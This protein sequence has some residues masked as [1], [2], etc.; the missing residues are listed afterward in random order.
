MALSIAALPVGFGFEDG[1]LREGPLDA[2]PAAALP[3]SIER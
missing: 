1:A 3:C 2:L